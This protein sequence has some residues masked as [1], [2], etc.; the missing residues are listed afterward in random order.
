M[1]RSVSMLFLTLL[2]S[3]PVAGQSSNPTSQTRDEQAIKRVVAQTDEYWNNH[4]FSKNAEL[5][6]DDAE[7]VN[8]VGQRQTRSEIPSTPPWFQKAFG[9]STIHSTVIWIKFIKPD[10]AA[11]DVSWEMTGGRCPDGSDDARP[12]TYRK[13]LESLVMTK[14]RGR[15]LV[16]VFHNMDLPVTPA[17]STR[18]DI[19][20]QFR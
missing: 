6:T 2:I 10:V 9:A 4:E 16:A 1:T 7:D 11:V 8:V 3:C 5:R 18:P 19:P 20:C 14:Q 12:Q 17:G 13:G 15:W